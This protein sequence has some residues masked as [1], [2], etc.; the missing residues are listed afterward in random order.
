MFTTWFVIIFGALLMIVYI[1]WLIASGK[2]KQLNIADAGSIFFQGSSIIGGL[3]LMVTTFITQFNTPTS[4][5]SAD[6]V[7]VFYGGICVIY[8]SIATLCN[9]VRAVNGN[10]SE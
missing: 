8:I 9:K 4:E 1:I 5:I 10:K 7:Y 6:K 3:K 2:F